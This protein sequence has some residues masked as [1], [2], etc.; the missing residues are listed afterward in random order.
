MIQRVSGVG[1]GLKTRTV[2]D[3]LAADIPEQ[4]PM[5]A[6]WLKERQLCMV[7]APTGV[8]KSLFAMGVALAIAGGGSYLGWKAPKPRKVLF[9]DGEMD[10]VDLRDRFKLL[11]RA[12]PDLDASAAADNVVLLPRMD[13][14]VGTE[15]PDLASPEGC[16]AVLDQVEQKSPDLVVF[17][18]LSTLATVEDENK[19]SGFNQV[20]EL[21]QQLKQRGTGSLVVHHSRK[22]GGGAESFRG[23]T[24][25]S[26]I[27]NCMIELRHPGNVPS[28]T[29]AAF[30]LNWA[31]YRGKRDESM[32]SLVVRLSEEDSADVAWM[33][34]ASEG[35]AAAKVVSAVRSGL[36]LSQDKIA[37]E[38]GFS[39]SQVSKLKSRAISEGMISKEEWEVCMS[40]A[41]DGGDGLDGLW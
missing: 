16:Q 18:N 32:G 7:Y 22:G 4:E 25:L 6:P 40:S 8:G 12:M 2:A 11:L 28:Q 41:S 17:D 1:E 39:K 37:R 15:F 30:E 19:A 36:Y 34:E 9:I 20:I 5:L 35:D 21:A 31:K 27:F 23:S 26:V 38:L 3:L 33:C 10:M 14:E 24:K 29:G 13:Q